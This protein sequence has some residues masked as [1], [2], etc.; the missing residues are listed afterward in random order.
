MWIDHV[1]FLFALLDHRPPNSMLCPWATSSPVSLFF[2]LRQV[3]LS[4]PGWPETCDS[5]DSA[6]W[7]AK[8]IGVC[9]ELF[10]KEFQIRLCKQTNSFESQA[11]GHETVHLRWGFWDY[12][13]V[14]FFIHL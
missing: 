12:R 5:L 6:S 13:K 14:A 11:K 4:C 10:Y 1:G 8:I 3:L 9:L 2:M 7:V